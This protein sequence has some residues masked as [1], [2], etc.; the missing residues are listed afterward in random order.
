MLYLPISDVL[1]QQLVINLSHENDERY[2]KHITSNVDNQANI[3]IEYV[4]TGLLFNTFVF[5]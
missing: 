2:Y 5:K 3:T 1:G 4:S